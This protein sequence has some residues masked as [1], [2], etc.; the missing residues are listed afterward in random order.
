MHCCSHASHTSTNASDCTA[1]KEIAVARELA[2]SPTSTTSR[3]AAGEPL[4]LTERKGIVHRHGF[5][6][7]IR[8]QTLDRDRQHVTN[9]GLA[10]DLGALQESEPR[11]G[12]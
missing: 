4:P 9:V 8:L 3:P 5:E 11:P 6:D 10:G 12:P 1:A 2:H 7:D